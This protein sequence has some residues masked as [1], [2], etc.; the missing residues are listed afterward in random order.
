MSARLSLKLLG[1]LALVLLAAPFATLIAVT[2]W[3]SFSPLGG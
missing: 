3:S 2:D 1:P